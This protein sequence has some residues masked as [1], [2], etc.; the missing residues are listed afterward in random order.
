[1]VADNNTKKLKKYYSKTGGLMESQYILAAI[2]NPSQKLS[3]FESP[4]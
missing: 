2:L 1:M 4:E 3:I